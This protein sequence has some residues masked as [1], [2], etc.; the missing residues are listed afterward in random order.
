MY[1][2]HSIFYERLEGYFY[3]FSVWDESNNCLSWGETEEWA[4]LLGVPVPRVL[5]RGSWDEELIRSIKVNE[6]TM[7]GYVLRPEKGFHYDDFLRCV[8][9][10]VRPNHVQT[11]SHWMHKPIKKNK[12]KEV[13]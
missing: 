1:A 6:E 9:K 5:Y 8:A 12:L 13:E 2:T 4:Q 10:W 11:D 3:L 7:E